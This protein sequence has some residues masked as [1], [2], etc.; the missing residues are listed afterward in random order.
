MKPVQKITAISFLLLLN[1]SFVVSQVDISM[2]INPTF[3]VGE[4]ISFDYVFSSDENI[5]ISYV[6]YADCLDVPQPPIIIKEAN[7]TAG[8][9]FKPPG[10]LRNAR[11]GFSFSPFTS[12][13]TQR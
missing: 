9:P 7:I 6:P 5:T 3:N 1:L 11:R 8:Q 12:Q 2:E 13:R 4:Q 10:T